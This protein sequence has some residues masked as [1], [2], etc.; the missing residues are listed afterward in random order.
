MCK[1]ESEW[2][3]V[4][5]GGLLGNKSLN[6]RALLQCFELHCRRSQHECSV[7]VHVI[8]HVCTGPHAH[9]TARSHT[10]V[11]LSLLLVSTSI[12]SQTT[13]T[14][15]VLLLFAL[16]FGSKMQNRAEGAGEDGCEEDDL[17]P[18]SSRTLS[19]A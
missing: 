10:I 12:D 8:K 19:S 1:N 5:L 3:W 2:R 16:L 9:I 4:G 17:S 18:V 7:D 14:E 6:F 11:L 15:I 13:A